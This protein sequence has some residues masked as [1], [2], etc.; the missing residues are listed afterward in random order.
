VRVPGLLEWPARVKPA[1]CDVPVCTSD[2][3]PTLLDLLGIRVPNQNQPLDG[4]SLVPLIDG[5]MKERPAPIGFW[6]SRKLRRGNKAMP[7]ITRD[8]GHAAWTDN[9]YKLHR[10][11]EG[12]VELYD[13]IDDPRE[14]KDLAEAQPETV[15]KMKAALET[16]QDSVLKSLG[17][18]DY[19]V[20]TTRPASRAPGGAGLP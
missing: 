8:E 7:A 6:Y 13:L 12:K 4:V 20:A 16:W 3:H 1:V 17:G 5:K 11:P 14:K 18:A 2:L 15:R 10:L 19:K 9:R